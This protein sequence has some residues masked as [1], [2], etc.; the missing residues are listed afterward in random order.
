METS[1]S[2]WL[3]F[4]SPL[5]LPPLFLLMI[6]IFDPQPGNQSPTPLYSPQELAAATL[7]GSKVYTTKAYVC[8]KSSQLGAPRPWGSE[9]SI[10]MHS[11]TPT[12]ILHTSGIVW[13]YLLPAHDPHSRAFPS[14]PQAHLV[15]T[16]VAPPRRVTRYRLLAL[17]QHAVAAASQT[18]LP[19]QCELRARPCGPYE[20]DAEDA[21]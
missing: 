15:L 21:G 20:V 5:L 12:P 11:T 8:E 7:I 3:L 17:R 16:H 18:V 10:C 2:L 19:V 1:Y 4:S 14:T 9:F 6:P 13:H